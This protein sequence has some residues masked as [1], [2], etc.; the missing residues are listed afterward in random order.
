[1]L[2]TNLPKISPYYKQYFRHL[3]NVQNF[4]FNRLR[5]KNDLFLNVQQM[6]VAILPFFS[7]AKCY[8]RK[9]QVLKNSNQF[10][11]V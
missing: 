2:S 4:C 7:A 1:M 10:S 9:K 5:E 11:A 3:P 6:S 8:S